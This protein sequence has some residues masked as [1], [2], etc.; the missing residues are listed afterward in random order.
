MKMLKVYHKNW[1][2]ATGVAMVASLGMAYFSGNIVMTLPYLV[3]IMISLI[4]MN[5]YR[6]MS[7][8]K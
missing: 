7:G 4:L 3:L 1:L 8:G 6:Q 5:Q 2:L